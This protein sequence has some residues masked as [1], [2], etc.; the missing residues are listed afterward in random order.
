MS[1]PVQG[2]VVADP[3]DLAA[4]IDLLTVCDLPY[5]DLTPSHL[6]LFHVVR[7]GQALAAVVG[8]ERF[9]NGGLL[10]SLAVAPAHRG[11]SLG[12][13]LVAAL[14]TSARQSG[15]GNLY[16][17]TLS[18]QK[19][20]VKRSYEVIVRTNVPQE[21]RASAEF[22]SLCPASAACMWKRLA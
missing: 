12:G 22:M 11:Q 16:L 17:L 3:T 4:V 2:P 19:Y 13:N 8:L 21:I 20:F 18:A 7:Q 1:N 6:A 14:E 9:E 5:Q 15:I 10:R